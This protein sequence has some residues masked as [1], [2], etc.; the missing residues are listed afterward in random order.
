MLR[1]GGGSVAV[2]AWTVNRRKMRPGALKLMLRALSAEGSQRSRD[3]AIEAQPISI[4][5]YAMTGHT[6]RC[7]HSGEYN[8]RLSIQVDLRDSQKRSGRRTDL[9]SPLSCRT[10][11]PVEAGGTLRFLM[12]SRRQFFVRSHASNSG[13]PGYGA[14]SSTTSSRAASRM[15]PLSRSPLKA[16]SAPSPACLRR[17]EI[18]FLTRSVDS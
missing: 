7:L 1:Q 16:T 9:T 13:E 15:P 3:D 5:V 8:S 14:L 10:A 6:F 18:D 17:P 4:A 2:A 12:Q 11:A